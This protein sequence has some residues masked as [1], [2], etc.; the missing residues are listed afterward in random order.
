MKFKKIVTIGISEP[1]LDAGY[2][3]RID[4][5]ADKRISLAKDSP[6]I[7]KQLADADCMLVNP[8][9]FKVEKGTIDAAPALKYI[10]ALSTAYAKIDFEHAKGRGIAVTNI[11]GYSTESVAEFVFGMILEHIRELEKGKKQAREGNYSEEGFTATEIKGKTF[12]I[13]GLGRIG[14]RVAEIAQG[15]GAD[16]RY[17]SRNR[18]KEAEARGVRYEDADSLIPKCDLLSLHISQ[19]KETE[20]YLN[21]ERMRKIKKGAIVVNTAPMDVVDIDALER[22]LKDKDMTFILDHSDETNPEDLKRLSK[23]DNCV[24]YPPIGFVTK[25]ARVAKQRIFVENI[26]NFLKGSPTNKV[27]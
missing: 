12:G 27:N 16:V 3:K 10:G 20:K 23:Y 22:R 1:S 2:W 5:L 24:I 4:S 15:F 21:D 8:F 14:A 13:I 19:T 11:P 17:W 26:E 25:E 18:K 6:D 9:A 7:G